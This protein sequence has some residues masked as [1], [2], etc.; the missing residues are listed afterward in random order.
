MWNKRKERKN[1]EN[2]LQ[3]WEVGKPQ[4]RKFCQDYNAHTNS[5]IKKTIRE[6]E[7]DI[8]QLEVNV[9][10]NNLTEASRLEKKKKSLGTLLHENAKGALIRARF[11]LLKDIDAP[12]SFFFN[13]EKKEMERKQMLHLKRANGTLTSDPKEMIAM[14]FY[15]DLFGEQKC[16]VSSMIFLFKDVPKL[17]TE[18]QKELDSDIMINEL[19]EAVQQMSVAKAPGTD[20]LPAEFDKH[21]WH[22]IQED[23]LEVFKVSLKKMN[24]QLV[25]KGLCFRCYLRKVILVFK[26]IGDQWHC[27][28]RIIKSLQSVFIK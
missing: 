19:S 23:M 26:K 2:I 14:N 6:L 27:F 20:R 16:D 3:W 11:S 8:E 28:V 4:I 25:V 15:K 5:L 21:F 9:V 1:Y 17:N 10:N 13:L 18:Q 7:R 24:Y 12:S 22:V